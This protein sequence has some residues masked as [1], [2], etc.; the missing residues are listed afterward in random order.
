[1]VVGSV[2]R[3]GAMWILPL[4]QLQPRTSAK[5]R[6]LAKQDLRLLHVSTEDSS[7]DGA[8]LLAPTLAVLWTPFSPKAVRVGSPFDCDQALANAVKLSGRLAVS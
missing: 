3:L 2:N 4:T 5:R 7:F 6:W 8:P 1:M